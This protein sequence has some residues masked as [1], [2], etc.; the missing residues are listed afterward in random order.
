MQEI[1]EENSYLITLYE[2]GAWQSTENL[3][4]M[5]RE[6]SANNYHLSKLNIDYFQ[7]YNAVQYSHKG[8]VSSG[9]ILAEEQVP[10][11]RIIRKIMEATD[12]VIWSMR[13]EISI[14]KNEQ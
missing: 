11:L 6:L 4:V 12:Q 7:A 10:E 13:S 9:K 2:S 3:R 14:I 8:S 1:L 5:L